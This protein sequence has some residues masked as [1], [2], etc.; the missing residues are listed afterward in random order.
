MTISRGKSI[1]ITGSGFELNYVAAIATGTAP[2]RKI[3]V[4]VGRTNATPLV[5]SVSVGTDVLALVGTVELGPGSNVAHFYCYE[6]DLTVTGTQNL[7]VVYDVAAGQAQVVAQIFSSDTGALTF[8]T[9]TW[10]RPESG[11]AGNISGTVTATTA[12][13][14]ASIFLEAGGGAVTLTPTSPAT[15]NTDWQIGSTPTTL[16]GSL[17]RDGLSG[18]TSIVASTSGG[19]GVIGFAFTIGEPAGTPILTGPSG[20]ATGPTQ[21]TIGVTSDTTGSISSLILPSATPAP[22]DAATLI[23][24]GAAV[25]RTI[26]AA[27][28]PQTFA[29]TGLTTNT[30]VK[31][32]WAMAGSNVVS[33]AAFTPN[34]LAISGAALS[35]QTG[36]AGAAFVWTGATPESLITNTGNGAGSWTATAGV[37]ASG[38]TVNSSTGILVAATL[39]TAG[40]YTITLQRTDGS[41]VPSAQTVTKTV[42]LTISA[43]GAA[44]T[45]TM[46]GPSSG[47][48]S[49]P[50][51]DFT[52]GANGTITGTI[53]VT[54]SDG[55]SGGTFTP[56]TVSISSGTPTGTFTYTPASTGVKTISVTNNGGL[57]NPSNISYTSSSGTRTVTLSL[58]T[59]GTNPSANLTGLRWAF[60][61]QALP[62][63]LATPTATGTN[64][65]TNSSGVI[66]VN[67]TGTT[68]TAGATGYLIVSDTT[69]SVTQSPSC[70]AFSAPVL[71]A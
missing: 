3:R 13:K 63:L 59:D 58:T 36:T 37:G 52:V 43:S 56:T 38:V 17:M 8:G 71:V 54:P 51:T 5:T 57:T 33:S 1:G 27:G 31:V 21:A 60:F 24:D 66:T 53:I 6:G 2:N 50:S 45:V 10:F 4:L 62:N 49:L 41:T 18:S 42:G 47:T 44:T 55:G 25:V 7:T 30:A 28:T 34:T 64:G 11:G 16:Y 22:A 48:V 12:Q 32:H 35:A 68:L 29:I 40:S 65:S 26:A 46:S 9:P 69:G 23:A 15:Q 67:V 61:D 14:V 70:K 39:G 19:Y 20:A